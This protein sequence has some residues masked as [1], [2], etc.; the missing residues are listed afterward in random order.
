MIWPAAAAGRCLTRAPT[1]PQIGTARRPQPRNC[2]TTLAEATS[3]CLSRHLRRTQPPD[4]PKDVA[5][6]ALARRPADRSYT[7][8]ARGSR[9]YGYHPGCTSG[10]CDQSSELMGTGVASLAPAASHRL[11]LRPTRCLVVYVDRETRLLLWTRKVI[12]SRRE[13]TYRLRFRQV[14]RP[15]G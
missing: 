7:K 12:G 15:S 2:F 4:L 9:R 11:P 1:G 5:R 8:M 10:R 14:T 3:Q 6:A 13:T